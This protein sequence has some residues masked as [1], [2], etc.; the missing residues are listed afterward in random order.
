MGDNMINLLEQELK[1]V[2]NDLDYESEVRLIVSSNKKFGDYQFNGAFNLAKEYRKSPF[3]IANEIKE[4]LETSVNYK[5]VE[6]VNGFVNLTLSDE[7]LV[8]YVNKLNDNIELNIPMIE[9]EETII[10][11]YG[12]AN[13][14]K[15]LH[16]GHLRSANIGE[17][18][19]R[20][21][22]AV[23]YKTISDV[24]LGDVGR[25]M[26][27][28]IK[29][30]KEMH[31]ELSYFKEPYVKED[32]FKITVDDLNLIYPRATLKA[33]EDEEYMKEAREITRMLQN[34][35][36]PYVDL[37]LNFKTVSINEIK[38]IYDMLNT[39]FDLW[40]GEYDAVPYVPEMTKYLIDNDYAY[41]DDGALIMDVVRE[42]DTFEFPP[43]IVLTSEG[44]MLYST[45]D[46][47]TMY[48]RMIDFKPDKMIYLTDKRQHL[49][50]ESTFRAAYQSKIVPKDVPLIHLGFGTIN[51]EDRTPFKT[52]DG[53]VMSLL[54]LIN[55]VEKETKKV[56]KANIDNKDELANLLAVSAIKYAD[57]LPNMASDYVFDPVNFSDL[58]GKTG[59]YL[60]YS[61]VRMKSLLDKS[62]QKA[63][64]YTKISTKEE[65]DMI[66]TLLN[67]KE[68]YEKSVSS[69]TL[70]ELADYIYVL[71]NNF[72]AFYNNHEVLSAE[73]E[74]KLN[75]LFIINLVHKINLFNLDVLG[76]EVPDKI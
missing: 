7:F 71:T 24:H 13:I 57:L 67:M 5:K 45:T 43:F 27:L 56:I 1:E 44:S 54:E 12:G 16:V 70:N 66:L 18:L 46:L 15:E 74:N 33:E 76:L 53:E 22:K 6:V 47:A 50:F 64:E 20:L 41:E 38:R 55:I 2:M 59:P 68:V 58:S 72:N 29:E 52:R 51:G 17:A 9:K 61:T 10:I 35:H 48:F 36:E 21:L 32:D 75:Y 23:G 69:Y 62:S 65:R 25:P 37:Y 40:Y 73:K 11:D 39:K 42:G 14:A 60:L 8:D 30:I 19:N 31:P 34:G 3:E 4:K 26:G 28:I 49:H 63:T